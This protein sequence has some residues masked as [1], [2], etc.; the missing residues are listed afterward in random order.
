MKLLFRSFLYSVH[1]IFSVNHVTIL[2]EF[3]EV[4]LTKFIQVPL[5]YEVCLNSCFIIRY[6]S[7]LSVIL[8]VGQCNL[9]RTVYIYI[10]I[11]TYIHFACLTVD[12]YT[13]MY[14]CLIFT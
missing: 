8:H 10:Y 4:H 2:V 1:L 14:L 13:S 11:Y 9:I 12:F 3:H 7:I 5:K 6:I